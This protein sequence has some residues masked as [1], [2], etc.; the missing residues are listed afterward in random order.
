MPTNVLFVQLVRVLKQLPSVSVWC[1][2]HATISVINRVPVAPADNAEI[3][4]V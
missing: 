3:T 2:N 1:V 4:P